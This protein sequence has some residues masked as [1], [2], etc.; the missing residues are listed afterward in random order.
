MNLRIYALFHP[1][2]AIVIKNNSKEKDTLISDGK[3]AQLSVLGIS[4][5][6]VMANDR[7]WA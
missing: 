5:M 4:D 7:S 6:P 1:N 3:R 2:K